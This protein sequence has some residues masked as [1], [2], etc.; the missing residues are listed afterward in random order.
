MGNNVMITSARHLSLLFLLLMLGCGSSH[1]LEGVVRYGGQTVAGAKV[2]V[3]PLFNGGTAVST[4][5]DGDGAFRTKA[6]IA[7]GDYVVVVEKTDFGPEPPPGELRKTMPK[8][9]LP[10]RYQD[11]AQSPLRLTIPTDGPVQFDLTDR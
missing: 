10:P 4:V 7:P 3:V 5:T 2:S 9:L 11:P 8:A 1:R 6:G